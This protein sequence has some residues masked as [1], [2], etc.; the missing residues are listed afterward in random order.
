MDTS[1]FLR[2]VMTVMMTILVCIRGRMILGTMVS[3]QIVAERMT[4]T[5]MVM[6][7]ERVHGPTTHL[8]QTA[9]TVM[10]PCIHR[11]PQTIAVEEMKTVMVTSMRIVARVMTLEVALHR[12]EMQILTLMQIRI[13]TRILMEMRMLEGTKISMV[14]LT[15]ERAA[16][17]GRIRAT[18]LELRRILV[19]RKTQ[20]RTIP[21][22]RAILRKTRMQIGRH[23]LLGP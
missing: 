12:T 7:T 16:V 1:P 11:C 22:R 17:M 4:M 21:E 2:V 19:V 10:R 13:Q 6:V 5:G 9:M 18:C 14:G 15:Q 20:G 3:T 8:L 23:P